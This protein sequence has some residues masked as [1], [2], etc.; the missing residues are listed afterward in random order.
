MKKLLAALIVASFM[1]VAAFAQEGTTAPAAGTPEAAAP[2]AP[3]DGATKADKKADKKAKKEAKKKAKKE[4]HSHKKH[5]DAAA[6]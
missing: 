2:A 1:S 4:K 5:K 6:N 3:T